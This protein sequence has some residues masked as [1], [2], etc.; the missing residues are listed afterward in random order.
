MCQLSD[1][2]QR[3]MV[4]NFSSQNNFTLATNRIDLNEA[5]GINC[6]YKTE[7]G[8]RARKISD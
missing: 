5:K 2:L 4:I 7:R 3:S 6:I 8:E 1:A